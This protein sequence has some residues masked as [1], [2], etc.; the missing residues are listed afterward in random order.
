M[1]I[2]G[3]GPLV[4]CVP[5]FSEGR[6]ER[7]I[8][9]IAA[10]V[11]AV[12]GVRLLD[13]D[14]GRAA[15]RTVM[16]FA[17][18]PEAVAEAAFQAIRA[19]IARIDMR[20]HHGEHPRLGAADVCPLV[21]LAGVTMEETARL[22]RRLGERVGR[23]LDVP[24]YLYGHAASAPHRA[25]L[26][27]V[28]AGQYEG[29]AAKLARPEWRP[30]FGPAELRP[31]SGA[32]ALGARDLL[33]AYNVDL[34]TADARVAAAIAADVRESGRQATVDG[35]RVR[36]PG[37][38]K[39]VRAL[40][41]LI[42]E[43]GRA[44]VSLNVTDLAATPVHAVWREVTQ[45]A[46]DRGVRVLGAELVGLIPLAS[47][48]AAGRDAL[49]SNEASEEEL[50][51]AAVAALGLD[52]L[53]PFDP[54]KKVLEY[55]LRDTADDLARLSLEGFAAAVAA[56]TPLPGGG[57]ATAAVGA[58]GAAL[59]AMVARLSA[60]KRAELAPQAELGRLLKD[61]LL[62]LVDEDARVYE[63]LMRARRLPRESASRARAV[64]E[65][66]RGAVE[67]PFRVMQRSLTVMG[68]VRA[69]VETGLPSAAADAAVGALAARAALRGAFLNVRVNVAGLDD[70]DYVDEKLL[71][72]LTLV[73]RADRLEREIL[74]RIAGSPQP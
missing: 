73:D 25:S 23:E 20:R 13:V 5:N 21:P 4:E 35:R 56:G 8:A 50:V 49:G 47:L 55:R 15:H 22:A 64:A 54:S 74:G 43:Y 3:P 34:D 38:L 67:V 12:G 59:G 69:V 68:L 39:G 51:A 61:E 33:V 62:R 10:A 52:A 65:A 17:G 1:E 44:Q 14:S 18:P 19:A 2:A 46:A 31:R 72:G 27:V 28:R 58:L 57:S 45:K 16:T 42:E 32:V 41:W 53:R 48:V 36:V 6:D 7:V 71:A 66:T 11:D 60:A 9:E 26:A 30:D 63:R 40:G 37:T 70:R 24:V 29:L